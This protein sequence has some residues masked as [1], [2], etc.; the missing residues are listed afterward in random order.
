M[1]SSSY[2]FLPLF[3]VFSCSFE[4]HILSIHQVGV[5]QQMHSFPTYCSNI[6]TAFGSLAIL[7]IHEKFYRDRP[8]GT[9]PSGELNTRG[10]AKYS[11]F[12]PV[13]SYICLRL[14]FSMF[15]D[16]ARVTNVRI[17]IIIIITRSS[18]TYRNNA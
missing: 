15:A 11:D 17:I 6:S 12:G 9:P 3:P 16:T 10:V 8:S 7:D 18:P 2:Q 1:T 13:E 5:A 14:R 4:C